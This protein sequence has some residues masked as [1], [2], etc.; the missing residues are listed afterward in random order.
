MKKSGALHG[1][2]FAFCAW[3]LTLGPLPVLGQNA[4]H[5]YWVQ[6]EGKVQSELPA[7]Y[8]TPYTVAE[9]GAFLS[10]KAIYRRDVQGIPVTEH[11][12]PIPPDYIAELE[13]M[14]AFKVILRSKWFNA[15]TIALADT[16]FDPNTLLDLPMVTDIK[17]VLAIE[18][19]HREP[20][21]ALTRATDVP[22]SA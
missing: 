18:S 22:P 4:P 2:G 9:P 12:L 8:T 17:S 16:T 5:R 20:I 6:F 19:D 11:D 14:S 13:S 7:G 21:A 3:F 10:P 15:V 1:L